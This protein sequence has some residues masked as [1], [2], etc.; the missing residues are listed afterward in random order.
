MKGGLAGSQHGPCA[1]VFPWREKGWMLGSPLHR[2]TQGSP[3][4][5][6]PAQYQCMGN[7]HYKNSSAH[8]TSVIV[9]G[10]KHSQ[11]FIP[12][13]SELWDPFP[14]FPRVNCKSLTLHL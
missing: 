11:G 12:E 13:L 5:V 4:P 9:L 3:L 10:A 8:L 6:D 7:V 2:S 14:P 1:G